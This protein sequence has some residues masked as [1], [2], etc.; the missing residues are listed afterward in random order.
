MG[1]STVYNV[2]AEH[3]VGQGRSML[4]SRRET[5]SQGTQEFAVLLKPLVYLEK[6]VLEKNIRN[7]SLE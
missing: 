3:K 2:A 5:L 6:H 4:Q 7:W 1:D